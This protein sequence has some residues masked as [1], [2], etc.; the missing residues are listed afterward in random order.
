MNKMKIIT[1]NEM[2]CAKTFYTGFDPRIIQYKNNKEALKIKIEREMKC[3]L[4][5]KNNIICAASH[6]TTPFA[7]DF[8]SLNPILLNSGVVIPSL[9]SDFDDFHDLINSE[10]SR[11]PKRKDISNFYMDNIQHVI[12]WGLN[13]MSNQFRS[14]YLCELSTPTSVLRTNLKSVDDLQIHYLIEKISEQDIFS[15]GMI[16]KCSLNFTKKDRKTL[17]DFRELIYH[18]TG[19]HS[20]NCE[21]AIPQEEYIDYSNVNIKKMNISLSPC[22]IFIK[23]FLEEILKYNFENVHRA[24]IIDLL[25]FE[26]IFKIRSIINGSKFIEKYNQLIKTSTELLGRNEQEGSL[27]S[28]MNKIIQVSDDIKNNFLREIEK[29]MHVVK[30]KNK[31]KN[32]G[33]IL[34]NTTVILSSLVSLVFPPIGAL[35]LFF[36]V[37]DSI[38]IFSN[39][40]GIKKSIKSGNILNNKSDQEQLLK[41]LK[42]FNIEN[43]TEMYDTVRLMNEI[44]SARLKDSI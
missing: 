40:Y 14:W 21:S 13:D 35:S 27:T 12:R 36:T 37:K 38:P 18:L 41:Y 2:G 9:R 1:Q 7:F 24:A 3:L 5:T 6:L 30:R 33:A 20:L 4:L 42:R 26:D 34:Y 11:S 23:L 22:T 29:E 16:D 10:K 8:F 44:V 39:I 31:N 15:R 19:A 25:T 28:D 43:G 17:R 32:A